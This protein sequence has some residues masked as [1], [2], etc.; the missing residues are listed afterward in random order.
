[1]VCINGTA[2]MEL[3]LKV[4]NENSIKDGNDPKLK[5]NKQSAHVNITSN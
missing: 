2:G 1:M 4:K 5:H 3:K